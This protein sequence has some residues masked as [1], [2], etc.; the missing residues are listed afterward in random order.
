MREIK[1]FN[2]YILKGDDNEL[3]KVFPLIKTK[4]LFIDI[5]WASKLKKWS[6]SISKPMDYSRKTPKIC[7]DY[8]SRKLIQFVFSENFNK[9]IKGMKDEISI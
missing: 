7:P 9:E 2:C 8:I 3:Y 4:G 5:F 6:V 1:L